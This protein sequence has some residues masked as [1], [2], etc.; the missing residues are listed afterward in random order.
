M[1]LFQK[2]IEAQAIFLNPFTICSSCKRKIV[3][4]S[5]VDEQT[6]GTYPLAN[7]LNGENGLNRLAQLCSQVNICQYILSCPFL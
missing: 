6:N 5:F 4:C 1:L 7:G 2:E 3:V